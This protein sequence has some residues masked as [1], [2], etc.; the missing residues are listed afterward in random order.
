MK[1]A[2]RYHESLNNLSPAD[3]TEFCREV[4]HPSALNS[5]RFFLSSEPPSHLKTQGKAVERKGKIRTFLGEP[6]RSKVLHFAAKST[7]LLRPRV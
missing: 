1:A 5:T 7:R 2:C 4:Q 6:E 3:V